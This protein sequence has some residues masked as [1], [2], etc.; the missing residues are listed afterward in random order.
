MKFLA[1]CITGTPLPAEEP[2]WDPLLQL[3]D[4]HRL[5]PL[6]ARAARGYPKPAHVDAVLQAAAR[7]SAQ[8]N[9]LLLSHTAH[10]AAAFQS[11]GIAPLFLKGPL[12]AHQIYGDLSLRVCGDVD[13]LVPAPQFM[14][15]A[16]R[17][18]QLG[19]AADTDLDESAIRKH[20]RFQH[21]LPFAHPDGTLVELH[22]DL[23][24][25]HYSYRIDL[26]QWFQDA[27]FV[28]ISG[29][30][31]PTPSP[32]HTLLLAIIH[33]TKHLW[34]RLD[35]LADAAGIIRQPLDWDVLHR[36]IRRAGAARAA[37]VAGYLLRDVL[38][39]ETPLL[40]DDRLAA[41]IARTTAET[42]SRQRDPTF[43]RTRAFDLAVRERAGDRLRYVTNLYRRWRAK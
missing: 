11:Y 27:R 6:L 8:R 43:W 25:P 15:A 29:H 31:L 9:L 41:R 38:S 34:T 28:V 26:S 40:E 7:A 37:A 30:S 32:A 3:A 35:L 16:A 18:A 24:Q 13:V 39:V 2:D 14:Q 23:A 19:Y 17:L 5:T 22:A 10:I 42:L 1:A 4:Y 36:D 20:L 21:D 12:L 33:G